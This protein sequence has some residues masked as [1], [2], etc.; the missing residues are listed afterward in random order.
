MRLFEYNSTVVA[1]IRHSRLN[2]D[3]YTVGRIGQIH[4]RNASAFNI[5]IL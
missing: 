4:K 2:N 3:S 5:K 1:V